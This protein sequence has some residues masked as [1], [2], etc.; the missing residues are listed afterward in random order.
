MMEKYLFTIIKSGLD[1]AS[2]TDDDI[3]PQKLVRQS[4]GSN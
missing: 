4:N 1:T 3:V 2:I